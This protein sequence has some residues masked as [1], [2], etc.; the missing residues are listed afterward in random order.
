MRSSERRRRSVCDGS[1]VLCRCGEVI[2]VYEPARVIFDDGSELP[3]SLLTLR[4]ELETPGSIAV[5]ERCY[6][7]LGSD[8]QKS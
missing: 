8:R 4:S 2:G 7:E 6:A 5:H 3:G 1:A